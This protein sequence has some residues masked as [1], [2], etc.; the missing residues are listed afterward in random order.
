[1]SFAGASV[2][3]DDDDD[4]D[5]AED[6]DSFPLSTLTAGSGPTT[7]G[8]RGRGPWSSNRGYFGLMIAVVA[9]MAGHGRRV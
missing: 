1:M 6:V 4:V 2:A 7:R 5:G 8:L 9:G 3:A